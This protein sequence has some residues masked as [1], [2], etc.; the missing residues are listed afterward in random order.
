[1]SEEIYSYDRR[2]GFEL[3]VE[4]VYQD[5]DTASAWVG[6]IYYKGQLKYKTPLRFNPEKCRQ[7]IIDDLEAYLSK[8][9]AIRT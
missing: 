3:A 1:M 9:G 7:E 2:C 8:F 4:P 5:G 6:A